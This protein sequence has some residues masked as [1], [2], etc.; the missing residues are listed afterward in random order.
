[1]LTPD[2]LSSQ[3]EIS[4]GSLLVVLGSR[5]KT[6]GDGT[7]SVRA[8]RLWKDLDLPEEMKLAES[9]NS[10]VVYF[11]FYFFYLYLFIS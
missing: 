10:C 8:P 5:L 2:Q 7:F 1:M 6:K 9:V 4:G 11:L 3:P